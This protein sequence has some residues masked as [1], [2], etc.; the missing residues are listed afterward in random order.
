[1]RRDYKN[2]TGL[3]EA[4]GSSPSL[5]GE[6][7][8]VCTGDGEFRP[9]ELALIEACGLRGRVHQRTASDEELRSL[10]H[11]A[12]AFAY[13]SLYEGFGIPPL[14]AMA[15]GCPVVALNVSSVPEV[16][17]PAAEYGLPGDP[18]SL[19]SALER[20]VLSSS[21]SDELRAAGKERIELFSWDECARRTSEV[22]KALA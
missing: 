10:Y 15:A 17:G 18:D 4:M 19:R 2:W 8:L 5:A 14:E 3:I 21:R 11:H 7:D 13:P 12:A 6:F 9:A 1:M 16:C 20:V 22:Y